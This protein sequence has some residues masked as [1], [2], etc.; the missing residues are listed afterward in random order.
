MENFLKEDGGLKKVTR[1]RVGIAGMKAP[2]RQQTELYDASGENKIGEVTSG[3]FSPSLKKPIAMGYVE[4]AHAKAGT[5]IMV[6]IRGKMQPAKVERMPFVET[7]Y[8]RA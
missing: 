1:K 5:D 8:Y 4:T 7:H 2:A 6:N 3:T